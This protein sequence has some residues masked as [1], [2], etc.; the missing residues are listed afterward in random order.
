MRF[1]SETY[2]FRQGDNSSPQEAMYTWMIPDASSWSGWASGDPN[3][4]V[5]D[6]A[7]G[8]SATAATIGGYIAHEEIHQRGDDGPNHNMGLAYPT[9]DTCAL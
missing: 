8:G 7:F 5:N 2:G 1:E 3:T 6:F 4:Y 9:G